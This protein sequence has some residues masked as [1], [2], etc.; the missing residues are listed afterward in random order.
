MG[1]L[2]VY[3]PV[4]SVKQKELVRVPLQKSAG[5]FLVANLVV[6]AS[7]ALSCAGQAPPSGGSPDTTPPSISN[8]YPESNTTGFTDKRITLEF[9]EYVDRRSVEESI[10]I[11]PDVGPLEFDWSGRE[12]EI[13]FEQSLRKNVT[14]VVTVGTDVIDIRNRNRMAESFSLAFSTGATLDSASLHGRVFDLKP[15]GITIFAYTFHNRLS[16]TLSP[17]ATK[18]DYVTQTGRDGTFKLDYLAWG[19]YRLFAIRDQFKNILY[20]PQIDQ[21]G[22]ASRDFHVNPANRAIEGIQFQLTIEDTTPPFVLDAQALHKNSVRVRFSETLDTATITPNTFSIVDTASTHSVSTK[23]AF[24]TISSPNVAQL[25]TDNLDST[26][27]YRITVSGVRDT[28]G[29]LVNPKANSAAFVGSSIP[30]TAV[31]HIVSIGIQDSARNV[32][33]DVVLNVI[34]NE[35]VKE[36]PFEKSFRFTDST[37]KNSQGKFTWWNS[38]AVHF[39]PNEPLLPLAWYS[40][41]IQ[42]D[43]LQDYA[44]NHLRDSV[45]VRRFQTMDWRKLGSIRGKVEDPLDVD[46]SPI[47][48]AAVSVSDKTAVPVVKRLGSVGEFS[49]DNLVEGQYVLRAFRDVDGNGKYTFGR[50]FPFMP[51][52]RFAAYPDTIKVRARWP[53]E[54]IALRFNLN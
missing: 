39:Q 25:V 29:N 11:S 18:P 46:K 6:C 32:A 10:F 30:D 51:S 15:D 41:R 22:M 19:T 31:P 49:F 9:S 8:T 45:F 4:H 53:V 5:A 36:T 2:F 16:D 27:M 34:I 54:G 13:R 26:R 3:Y 12:V 42:L 24:F 20:D 28:A 37:G 7:F 52:E 43:S 48:I 14:Y 23:D 17:A 33:Y 50:S 35:A 40:I 47:F 44:G 21:I 1:R 38:A